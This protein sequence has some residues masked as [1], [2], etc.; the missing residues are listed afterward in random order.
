MHARMLRTRA[1]AGRNGFLAPR[2]R[3]RIVRRAGIER[4]AGQVFAAP[5]DEARRNPNVR[6]ELTHF[7]GAVRGNDAPFNLRLVP[8]TDGGQTI[9]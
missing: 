5:N 9:H 2:I 7:G 3:D 4:R 8:R 1:R 6:V